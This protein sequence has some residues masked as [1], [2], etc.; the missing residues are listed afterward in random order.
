MKIY[1]KKHALISVAYADCIV[2]EIRHYLKSDIGCDDVL[3]FWESSSDTSHSKSL[4]R[5]AL[6][7]PA[8]PPSVNRSEL[9]PVRQSGSGP[10]GPDKTGRKVHPAGRNR[11][12]GGFFSIFCRISAGLTSKMIRPDFDRTGPDRMQ[13]IRPV[14]TLKQVFSTRNLVL[15][16]KRTDTSTNLIFLDYH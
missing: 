10:A 5:T 7:I 1:L 11:I 9:E 8:T 6:K 14:P 2:D 16:A 3:R 15:N 12:F 13:K 4:P